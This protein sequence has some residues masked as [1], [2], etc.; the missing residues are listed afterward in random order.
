MHTSLKSDD[1]REYRGTRWL[2]TLV[3]C[4]F[5]QNYES[6]IGWMNYV[7]SWNEQSE[8]T[9]SLYW[10]RCWVVCFSGK[11]EENRKIRW[12]KTRTDFGKEGFLRICVTRKDLRITSSQDGFSVF[13]SSR[14]LSN[15]SAVGKSFFLVLNIH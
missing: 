10:F 12:K 15:S 3:C 5:N 11:K 4:H 6:R 14:I 7:I 2:F 13:V 1:R 8:N 9:T